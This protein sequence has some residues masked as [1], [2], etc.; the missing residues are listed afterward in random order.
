MRLLPR[1]TLNTAKQKL[2]PMHRYH[3]GA[4]MIPTCVL[5]SSEAAISIIYIV[6]CPEVQEDQHIAS[7]IYAILHCNQV[8][9]IT[10]QLRA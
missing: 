7:M 5:C 3:F 4:N 8:R 1:C 10:P 2:V 9:L 6:D